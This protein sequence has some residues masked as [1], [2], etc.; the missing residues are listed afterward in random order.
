MKSEFLTIRDFDLTGKRVLLRV[1]INS[2]IDPISGEILG[3]TRIIQ[4]SDTI[5]QLG[6]SKLIVLAH[7][8]RPGKA[9]FTSLKIHADKIS[10]NIGRP[11]KFVDDLFGSRAREAILTLND[12]EVLLLENTRLYSE[13]VK[14][15]DTPVK[16]QARTHIVKNLVPLIDYYV[17]D[18]FAAAHRSQPSLTGFTSSIPSLAGP[19]VEREV[20]ALN[21]ALYEGKKPVVVILGGAKVDDSIMVAKHMLEQQIADKI[22]TTGVVANAFMMA[23]DIQLGKESHDFIKHELP[24]F[25]E[26]MKIVKKLWNWHGEQIEI[27]VDVAVNKNGTRKGKHVSD[28]PSKYQIADIG[29]DTIVNY[30]EWINEANTIILNGPA[31]IFELDEF[32]FGTFE[33]F[34]AVANSSAY[35]VVGGGETAQVVKMLGLE[36]KIGHVST[37]GG[38]CITYLTGKPLPVLEELKN[39]KKLYE[40]GGF[41]KTAVEERKREIYDYSPIYEVN[42][43]KKEDE[44]EKDLIY[45]LEEE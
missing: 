42:E 32:A 29:L 17:N 27:P 35:S 2:P 28:L 1:D 18:A 41:T 30:S 40:Q 3:D 11:V 14:L 44:R 9:D 36:N 12:G 4:H 19:I 23:K 45:E 6:N 43:E 34:K 7:Q 38:A 20:M 15:K 22:L 21:K 37:G 8:S 13:E 33:L 39:S 10:Y 16:T 25:D 31:G 26:L 24:N 5:R